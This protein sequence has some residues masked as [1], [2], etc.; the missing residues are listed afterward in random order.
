MTK[1]IIEQTQLSKLRKHRTKFS[2]ALINLSPIALSRYYRESDILDQSSYFDCC[3]LL[4]NVLIRK[5]F[6]TRSS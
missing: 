6:T 3:S 5:R 4:T 2:D 1:I